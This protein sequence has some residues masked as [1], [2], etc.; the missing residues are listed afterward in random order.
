MTIA[1][2]GKHK[3]YNWQYIK[4][5]FPEYYDWASHKGMVMTESDYFRQA[6]ENWYSECE[7]SYRLSQSRR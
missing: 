7:R 5:Q 6:D 2:V 1:K 3:G 4:N